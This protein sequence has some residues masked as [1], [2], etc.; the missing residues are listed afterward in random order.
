MSGPRA[1]ILRLLCS[2]PSARTK[3]SQPARLAAAGA[4]V[5]TL[6]FV[7]WGLN[8]SVP[9]PFG[10]DGLWFYAALVPLILGESLTE[11]FFTKPA[12][13]VATAIALVV[14]CTTLSLTDIS[15]DADLAQ[16]GRLAFI[17]YGSLLLALAI[18]AIALKDRTGTIHEWAKRDAS[19]I[20]LIGQ[21]RCVFSP[22]LLAVGYAAFADD[23]HKLIA[24]Y[25]TWLVIAYFAP[26]EFLIGSWLRRYGATP[27]TAAGVVERIEDPGIIIARLSR[28]TRP[29]IG[30]TATIGRHT[31]VVVDATTLLD[32]P[33]VR[34]ALH[35]GQPT[36]LGTRVLLHDGRLDREH[37]VI[38]F[39]GERTSLTHLH[40]R[41]AANASEFGL[42]EARLLK[43]P[44]AGRD[45]L[46]QITGAAIAGEPAT[47]GPRDIIEVTAQKLGFWN[48]AKGLFEESSWLPSPGVSVRLL[49]EAESHFAADEIGHVPGSAYGVRLDLDKAVT[50]NT[51]VLGVLGTGKTHLAWELIQRMLHHG[52]KV[53]VLDITAEYS[54]HFADVC[55]PATERVIT[56]ELNIS[57]AA[58]ID[59]V[60]SGNVNEFSHAIQKRLEVFVQ[61]D[62]QLLVL[63]PTSLEVSRGD[64]KRACRLTVSEIT[65]IIAEAS[66]SAVSDRFCKTARLCLALEE[67]HS[68]VPEVQ[69]SAVHGT[70]R[71]LLQGRKY[72]L[73]C[74]LITQRT[75]NVTK[76]IL[77]QCSTIVALR[78]YD[79]GESLQ[80]Y[81]GTAHAQQLTALHERQAVIFGRASSCSVPIIVKLN[82]SQQFHASFLASRLART[83]VTLS[84]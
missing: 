48:D 81:I 66:L 50:H 65:Q 83:P 38:G 39:V 69:S 70:A 19:L 80:S 8:G 25:V 60:E 72:G 21:P 29:H 63:N 45:V 13:V 61:G 76:S 43:A 47:D 17:C 11:P 41:T 9:P 3:L 67:A 26:L 34:I 20:S 37:P 1:T 82:D 36:A 16:T 46:F 77:S 57:I 56:Q 15:I 31:G 51:A 53:L 73:G 74:L 32:E 64:K 18:L 79:S 75:A 42:A 12:D 59:N 71:A 33:R 49:A 28:G 23:H 6:V 40:V 5:I 7:A 52:I 78:T 10:L 24:L 68:L 30:S 27:L 14:A 84:P 54:D 22:L 58:N 2:R 55:S 35:T 62:E 44:I 4:Y